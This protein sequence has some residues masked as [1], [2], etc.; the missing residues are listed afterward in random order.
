MSII[1][2]IKKNYRKSRLKR[3]N[4]LYDQS[5]VTRVENG[6]KVLASQGRTL[7]PQDSKKAEEYA[8]TVLGSIDFAPWLKLYTAYR[9]EFL[10]GWIPDNYLGRVVC[11]AV[12][13][14]LRSLGQYKTLSKKILQT[15]SLP[16]LAY[17]I[18]GSWI[19]IA[20][21]PS[22][23]EEVRS[24]CFDQYPYVFL[25]KDFSFQGNGVIKLDPTGFATFDFSN[26]GDFVIQAPIFQHPLLEEFSP[27][28]VATLRITTVKPPGQLAKNRLCALRIGRK[29]MEY[30]Y[31]KDCI[32]VPIWPEDGRLFPNATSADW[33]IMEKHP[34][35]GA[36]FA[37]KSIPSFH[38]A[39]RLCENL[40]DRVPH[41]QL[42]G[43][44]AT[45]DTH[46]EVKLMEWNTDEP[47]IVFSEPTTGPHFKGLGWEELWKNATNLSR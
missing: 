22:S 35:T 33:T 4:R 1:Q 40:H 30:I 28:A 46:G 24:I 3:W 29:G 39:V 38:Q 10:E 27:G 2:L 31:T 34:D 5:H 18:K 47:G 20:G 26:A 12:N 13:G 37:G 36:H 6:L 16:D 21:N 32:R 42:I 23:K 44:D 17:F 14:N 43:W 8:K 15:E 45:I 41:F 11:P 19:T 9:G 25:K 7:S